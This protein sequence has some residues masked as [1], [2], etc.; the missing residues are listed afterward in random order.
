[1]SQTV[2]LLLFA[3][4]G[5]LIVLIWIARQWINEG[6]LPFH[7]ALAGALAHLLIFH[8]LLFVSPVIC[9]IYSAIATTAVLAW[10]LL[11]RTEQRTS[12]QKLALEDVA[13]YERAVAKRPDNPSFHA[14]LAEAYL[15]AGRFD[16][17]IA[18]LEQAIALDTE[19][20]YNEQRR[21]REMIRA[22]DAEAARLAQARGPRRLALSLLQRKPAPP[23]TDD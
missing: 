15:A 9:L 18:A 1:M 23:P 20:A 2:I 21:L 4:P 3:Y 8:V 19:P 5:L 22:R 13:Q 17:A 7:L 14:R 11:Q 12:N 16:E 6:A 10:P